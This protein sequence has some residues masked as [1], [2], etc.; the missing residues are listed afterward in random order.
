MGRGLVTTLVA[1][2]LVSALTGCGAAGSAVQVSTP[3]PTVVASV[4]PSPTPTQGAI[5]LATFT[6]VPTRAPLVSPQPVSSPP[7]SPE[8]S[9]PPAT[10][11]SPV[12][13]PAA[14]DERVRV[15][16]AGPAGLNL[17][18]DPGSSAARVKTVR[19][20][21]VLEI[22]GD[23]RQAD[24]RTWRNVRDPAD[25]ATGWAAAQFLT[26]A[27]ATG[28][29]P[30]ASPG[31]RGSA[32]PKPS[33][34]AK[35]SAVPGS[36]TGPSAAGPAA[37]GGSSAQP[38]GSDCPASSPIKGNISASGEQIYHVPGGSSYRATRPE[39]CFASPQEAEAAG[40]RRALR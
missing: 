26:A 8:P 10:A 14:A 18:A 20:G 21:A 16:G 5:L 24:D 3:A 40:F 13:S 7:T 11:P 28:V 30:A 39:A 22:I 6:L 37:P 34:A 12:A 4:A 31:P 33:A 25:G 27:G 19:D 36:A 35:P 32:A 15:S 1:L 38:L 23:D 17:R 9:P 2:A 29:A